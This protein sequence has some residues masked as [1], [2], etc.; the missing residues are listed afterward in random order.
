MPS[1]G[2][3]DSHICSSSCPLQPL[4]SPLEGIFTPR[5]VTHFLIPSVFQCHFALG[6][7]RSHFLCRSYGYFPQN[8][9]R[10]LCMRHCPMICCSISRSMCLTQLRV[11]NTAGTRVTDTDSAS[12]SA[13]SSNVLQGAKPSRASERSDRLKRTEVLPLSAIMPPA[14]PA[15]P[16]GFY[17]IL[18][19]PQV[20]FFERSEG[21]VIF[22]L[23]LFARI[24]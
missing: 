19:Q 2:L 22:C 5:W 23:I 14:L 15:T 18:I 11:W 8:K 13:E 10:T 1:W 6:C 21:S 7:Q 4:S 9:I 24:S 16:V 12:E 20:K 17:V 3:S